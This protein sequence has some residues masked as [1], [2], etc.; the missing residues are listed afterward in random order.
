MHLICNMDCLN[1]KYEDGCINDSDMTLIERKFSDSLN[2]DIKNE[3]ELKVEVGIGMQRYEHNRPDKEAYEKA[4]DAEYE[5]KRAG[6]PKRKEQKRQQYLRHREDKL[7]YSKKYYE[8][9]KEEIKA[10][11]R[12]NKDK[13]VEYSRKYYAEHKEEIC[14]KQRLKYKKRKEKGQCI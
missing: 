13:N 14:A 3:R 12:A 10:K 9:H 11:H 4:R 7:A 5:A 1:C 2:K 8:E 6:T